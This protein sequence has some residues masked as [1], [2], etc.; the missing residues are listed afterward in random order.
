MPE[1]ERKNFADSLVEVLKIKG[2]SVQKL[3]ELTGI[4]ENVISLIIE[5]K[6]NKLPAA[7]YLHGYIMKISDVLGLDGD[8]AWNEFSENREGIKRSGEKDTPP[9]NRF[10]APKMNKAAIGGIIVAVLIVAYL[11]IRL[12]SILGTPELVLKNLPDA[13]TISKSQNF[14]IM[15]TLT[16]GDELTVNDESI[17]PQSDGTFKKAVVLNPGFNTFN[18]EATKVLGRKYSVTKQI[19]YQP[20]AGTSTGTSTNPNQTSTQNPSQPQ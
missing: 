12:P 18:F 1:N 11:T 7:P 20:E 2:I 19:F 4:P 9:S 14:T 15:G 6:F 17:V 16:S 10:R 5:E 3:S 13:I 8:A